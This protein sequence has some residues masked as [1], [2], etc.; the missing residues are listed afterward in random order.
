MT[1]AYLLISLYL[2]LIALAATTA[3]AADPP[4]GAVIAEVIT[5][6]RN[7]QTQLG[8][9]RSKSG[10]PWQPHSTAYRRWQLQLWTKRHRACLAALHERARQWNWQAW[11]PDKWRRIG[12]CETGLDWTFANR[13]YVSAF[14]IS[15]QA[16]DEDAA[17]M[18]APPWN[19]TRKPSPWNQYRAAL[20]HAKLH[21]GL[22]GWGCRNA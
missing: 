4:K 8:V 1:T 22:S 9:P 10:N 15:R 7:C 19:D 6:T 16:Y 12:T 18:G 11:L 13:V 21:G 20:G 17:A 2:V 5:A 3:R 14:G